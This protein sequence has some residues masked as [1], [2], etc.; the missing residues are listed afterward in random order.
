MFVYTIILYIQWW[1]NICILNLYL[2]SGRKNNSA[3]ITYFLPTCKYL[4]LPHLLSN[5]VK[6]CN[7]MLAAKCTTFEMDCSWTINYPLTH[8]CLFQGNSIWFSVSMSIQ[9]SPG[10]KIRVCTKKLIFLF[11]IQNICCG[12]SKEPSQ[13]DGSFEHPKHMIKLM[14]KK[15]FTS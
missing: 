15:I 5:L 13:W 3:P 2:Q 1:P 4:L 6:I 11:L 12:Y 9:G 8:M 7:N 14:G 10:L